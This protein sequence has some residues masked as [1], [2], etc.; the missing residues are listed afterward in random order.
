M[1]GAGVDGIPGTADDE[2]H[3]APLAPC[4]DAGDPPSTLDADVE[5]NAR[6]AGL[7]YDMGAYEYQP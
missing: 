1:D 2:L 3:L 7:G 6:P 4:I 5:G